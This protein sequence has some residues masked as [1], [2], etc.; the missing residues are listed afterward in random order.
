[1]GAPQ[2]LV[3]F[4]LT[5]LKRDA[6]RLSSKWAISRLTTKYS[7]LPLALG[8]SYVKADTATI[9]ADSYIHRIRYLQL[10]V[11]VP[12]AARTSGP[13]RHGCIHKSAAEL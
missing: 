12:L 6:C 11:G 8:H 2:G 7:V 5:K 10:S 4:Y 1:M 9:A 3:Q 13:E